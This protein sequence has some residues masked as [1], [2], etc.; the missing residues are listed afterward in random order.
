MFS[1]SFIGKYDQETANAP[2]GFIVGDED[3]IVS[4]DKQSS[5]KISISGIFPK[6]TRHQNG[7]RSCLHHSQAKAGNYHIEIGCIVYGGAKTELYSPS[8]TFGMVKVTA[9]PKN[10]YL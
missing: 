5:K 6:Y 2:K 1:W 8:T 9:I 10:L 3:I 4:L 7:K